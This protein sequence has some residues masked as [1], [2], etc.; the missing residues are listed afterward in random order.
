MSVPRS[1]TADRTGRLAGTVAATA[2]ATATL[3]LASAC[4]SGGGAGGGSAAARS[5]P[6]PS[7]TPVQG[8]GGRAAGASCVSRHG[9]VCLTE[10]AGGHTVQL[11]VDW[12]LTLRLGGPGRRFSAPRQYGGG[13]ALRAL[14]HP[15][16]SG[17]EVI[18]S[19]Q[20]VRPGTVQ[21]RATERPLCRSGLACPDYVALWTLTVR[22]NRRP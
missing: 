16:R 1:G 10:A 8:P 11:T 5:A 3:L 19:F 18:A 17:S 4:G 6:S 2:L 20:A 22:V 14:G 13:E 9:S 15:Q 21:L 12:K 7:P